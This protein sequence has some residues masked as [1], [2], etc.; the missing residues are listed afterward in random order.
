MSEEK[1]QVSKH[2]RRHHVK[3]SAFVALR[4]DDKILTTLEHSGDVGFPGGKIELN[5]GVFD[6]LCREFNE[7]TGALLPRLSYSFISYGNKYH[8][9]KVY[10]GQI[11]Q[12]EMDEIIE[13]FKER[14]TTDDQSE[15]DQHID[16]TSVKDVRVLTLD[17]LKASKL[18]PHIQGIISMLDSM[19]GS[20]VADISEW[21]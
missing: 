18:R 1:K 14:D 11:D 20:Q 7:E 19:A 15:A 13:Q 21:K 16:S 10:V 4:C 8:E 5:E 9:V 6:G 2:H 3:R 12:D 17:E